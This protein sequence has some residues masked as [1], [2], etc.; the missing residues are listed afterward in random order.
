[1]EDTMK[2]TDQTARQER[3]QAIKALTLTC[4]ERDALHRNLCPMAYS[5]EDSPEVRADT[6]KKIARLTK[7]IAVHVF[8]ITRLERGKYGFTALLGR[9]P[10]PI[11]TI[12][13]SLLLVARLDPSASREIWTVA[14]VVGYTASRDLETS[15]R[16]RSMFRGD[17]VL[18][19][20]VMLSGSGVGLDEQRARLAESVVNKVLGLQLDPITEIFSGLE[21]RR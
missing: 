6:L 3:L 20:H 2:Q 18:S 14:D 19:S 11:E 8:N 15:V 9:K 1:M 21:P 13:L 16:V 5:R 7:V 10:E 4:F 12:A 17:G